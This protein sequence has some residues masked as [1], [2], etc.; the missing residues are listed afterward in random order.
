MPKKLDREGGNRGKSKPREDAE[1]LLPTA[2]EL[3]TL[4]RW[5]RVAFVAR[6]ARRVQPLF[7]Q[8]WSDAPKER[9]EA[10]DSAITI[11]ERS[12]ARASAAATDAARAD[13]AEAA[14]NAANAVDVA[15]VRAAYVAYSA[16]RAASAIHADS[17][18]AAARAASAAN[19]AADAAAAAGNDVH[20]AQAA[21]VAA[22]RRDFELLKAAAKAAKWTDDTPVPPEFFGPL[23][24]E[25]EPEG[26][27]TSSKTSPQRIDT[28]PT[29]EELA[30]LPRWA[31]VA[32]A[33]R[34]ARRVQPLFKHFWPGAPEK[35]V[36]AID[37]AITTIELSAIGY[38]GTIGAV[39]I[40]R[41]AADN[42][43]AARAVVAG[44]AAAA[45]VSAG[46]AA[47]ATRAADSASTVA[48]AA[49]AA[50]RS[51]RAAADAT[52][53]RTVASAAIRRDF[54]LLK[55]AAEAENW[56]DDTPVPP[57]FFGP[58]WPH[59]EPEDWPESGREDRAGEA[60]VEVTIEVPEDADDEAIEG[61]IKELAARLD[62]AHRAEGGRG[63]VI[64]AV[65]IP[66][67][68]AVEQGVL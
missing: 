3:A 57:E 30:T 12:A 7:T 45:V 59:G 15:N 34:C 44:T 27:P 10:V 24:P 28:L 68:T 21:T 67:R 65:E 8:L 58:L 31:C 18:H 40:A 26:W 2:E 25:G 61:A 50:F 41:A 20:A 39:E 48:A 11:S 55:A 54:E 37:A 35:H 17:F 66:I 62:D 22:M 6:C 60:A 4:P 49:T 52:D 23:W 5:A 14:A 33:A 38:L 36:A 32:F 47:A 53:A 46:T 64:D 29:E 42:A 16:A 9:V 13:A 56:T 1:R 19:A 63:I 43:T 51:A